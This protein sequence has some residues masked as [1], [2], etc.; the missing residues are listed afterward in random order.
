MGWLYYLSRE[1]QRDGCFQSN[2]G[3]IVKLIYL[4]KLKAVEMQGSILVLAILVAVGK[5]EMSILKIKYR[6]NT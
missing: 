1:I 4:I 6:I 5:I 2:F 3:D